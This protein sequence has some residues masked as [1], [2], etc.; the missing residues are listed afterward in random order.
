MPRRPPGFPR[1]EGHRQRRAV[2]QQSGY[3]SM[4]PEWGAGAKGPP[5]VGSAQSLSAAAAGLAGA[6][7]VQALSWR[8]HGHVRAAPGSVSGLR[9][10]DSHGVR[11]SV[12]LA[13]RREQA[14]WNLLRD[15][16]R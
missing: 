3:A 1:P 4:T 15:P 10:L 5:R 11:G 8:I 12:R 16:A 9:L 7:S 2:A 13:R 14:E 6:S